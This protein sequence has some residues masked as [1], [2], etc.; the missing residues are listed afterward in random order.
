[1]PA[2]IGTVKRI[3]PSLG[4]TVEILQEVALTSELELP[5]NKLRRTPTTTYLQISKSL[6][7]RTLLSPLDHHRQRLQIND[8]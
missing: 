1:M 3:G 4:A 6:L 7:S 5:P 2:P 8:E